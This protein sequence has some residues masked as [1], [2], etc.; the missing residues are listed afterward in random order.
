MALDFV[1][2]DVK[3]GVL[4]PLDGQQR[5]TTLF[6]STGT[7][8]RAPELDPAAPWLQFSYATRPTARDFCETIA[9][10]PFPAGLAR[11]RRGSRTSLGT[12]TLAAG[13][14]DLVHAR[15]ARR[16][17]RAASTGGPTCA[18]GTA[19]EK[20]QMRPI[21]FL[22]LPVADMDY[23]EDLY[24]KMN[25]R[26][27]PLTPFEVFKADLEG[28]LKPS[29]GQPLPG[30][31]AHHD[32]YEHL[33]MSIDG[34]W[35]DVLWEYEKAGARLCHRRRVHALPDLH[36]RRLRVARRAARPALARQGSLHANGRSRNAPGFRSRTREPARR[37][38]P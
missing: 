20:R 23:G 1:Y 13:P 12:S 35:A 22:F 6:L 5:L 32:H 25:S 31:R 29:S 19:C 15:D 3:D 37:E 30:R 18:S 27:K 16:D 11:R 4:R 17:P 14:D 10:H 34:A 26:G 8:L 9:E 21:W 28:M 2:G 7:S 24:I 33:T 38:E 36:H